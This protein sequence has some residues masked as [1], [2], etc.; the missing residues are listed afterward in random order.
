MKILRFG[1]MALT[2]LLPE[3]AL[4]DSSFNF[5]FSGDSFARQVCNAVVHDD[6]E[7]LLRLLR[8]HRLTLAYGY[9]FN[10][11]DRAITGSFKCNDMDLQKFS[12]GIG[13]NEISGYLERGSEAVN[14]QVVSSGK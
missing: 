10:E 6:V 12:E 7:K 3:V 2:I 14:Q 8:S 5:R 4:P 11:T 13:A 1:L 9:S